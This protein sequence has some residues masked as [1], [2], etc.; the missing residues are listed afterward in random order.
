[1][2]RFRDDEGYTCGFSGL[3]TTLLKDWRFAWVG[4]MRNS[5]H[6]KQRQRCDS[7]QRR[8]KANDPILNGVH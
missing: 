8:L 6:V 2:M 7:M 4:D 5:G 1:M 3:W